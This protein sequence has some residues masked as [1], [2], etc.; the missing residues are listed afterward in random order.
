MD[1]MIK[2]NGVTFKD[3]EKNIFRWICQIGQEFTKEFLERYDQQLMKQRDKNYYR[4]KGLRQTTI[5]TVW[6]SVQ[7]QLYR[8][9]SYTELYAESLIN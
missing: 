5:K 9:F 7:N 3:L 1:T 2:E 6:N 8:T 4:H